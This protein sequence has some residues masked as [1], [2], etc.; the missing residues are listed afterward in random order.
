MDTHADFDGDQNDV[1]AELYPENGK[2]SIYYLLIGKE[3]IVNRRDELPGQ[4][5]QQPESVVD[6]A[7]GID[8]FTMTE[9]ALENL[10]EDV[11]DELKKIIN[12]NL[13]KRCST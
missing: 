10:K 7:S 12:L 4:L 6:K 8:L 9:E 5:W 3:V 1:Y 2:Y 11:S 13:G